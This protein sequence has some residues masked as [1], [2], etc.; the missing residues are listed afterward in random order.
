LDSAV[1]ELRNVLLADLPEVLLALKIN[2]L[3]ACSVPRAKTNYHSNQQLFKTTVSN[4]LNQLSSFHDGTG[5]IIRNTNTR[6]THLPLNT[7]NYNNDGEKPYPGITTDT[8]NIS[9]E[10]RDKDIL[11]IDDIFTQRVNID[12]DAIQALIDSE[13]NSVVFYAV[14]RTV[15]NRF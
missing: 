15:N 9:N 5:Y 6:T 1:H 12:E 10:V 13:A 8:C 3:T 4:V 7:P 11:L 14:A 2:S